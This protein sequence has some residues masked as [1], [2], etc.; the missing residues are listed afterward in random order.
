VGLLG[1]GYAT[2]YLQVGSV[3]EFEHAP[4]PA[5]VHVQFL[6]HSWRVQLPVWAQLMTQPLPGHESDTFPS[7]LVTTVQPPCGQANEQLPRPRQANAQ[8][9]PVQF[10]VQLPMLLQRHSAPV[11]QSPVLL[12]IC[13]GPAPVLLQA[14]KANANTATRKTRT[15][16]TIHV[17]S[18][19]WALRP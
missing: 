6:V 16:V 11:A 14:A 19:T 5:C 12:P 13:V 3:H 17:F 2:G 7:P 9:A 4:V 8:P 18:A 1:S 10:L 15:I